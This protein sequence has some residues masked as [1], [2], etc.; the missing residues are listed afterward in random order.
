MI[1]QQEDFLEL[2]ALKMQRKQMQNAGLLENYT[3]DVHGGFVF[4]R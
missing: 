1:E 2:E 3:I 4:L